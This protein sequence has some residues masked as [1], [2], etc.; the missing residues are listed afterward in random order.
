MKST[1]LNLIFGSFFALA[2]FEFVSVSSAERGIFSSAIGLVPL[3]AFGFAVA[4]AVAVMASS[5]RMKGGTVPLGR[6][7]ACFL[8]GIVLSSAALAVLRL[9]GMIDMSWWVITLPFW[10]PAVLVTLALEVFVFVSLAFVLLARKDSNP[11]ALVAT[12]ILTVAICMTAY[13]QFFRSY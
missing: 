10:G 7:F 13:F 1:T 11:W 5:P 9:A 4:I 3:L 8:K 6:T 12:F 2:V